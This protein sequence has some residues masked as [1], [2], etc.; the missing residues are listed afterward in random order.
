MA[1]GQHHAEVGVEGVGQERDAGGGQ[2][3]QQQHVHTGGREPRHDGRL[4]ELARDAGVATHD[5]DGTAPGGPE[6]AA[7]AEHVCGR[8]GEVER[9]LGGEVPVGEAPH[10]VGSEQTTHSAR[11]GGRGQRLLY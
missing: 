10:P 2:D 8:D 3:A 7:L 4:E 5:S 1:G 11:P 6:R 9:E